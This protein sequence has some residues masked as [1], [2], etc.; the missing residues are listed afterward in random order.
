MGGF[1]LPLLGLRIEFRYGQRGAEHRF[2]AEPRPERGQVSRVEL[3]CRSDF[4]DGRSTTTSEPVAVFQRRRK[5]D[6]ER[7]LPIG[8]SVAGVKTSQCFLCLRR[9]IGTVRG[10][11]ET[12]ARGQEHRPRRDIAGRLMV[13]LDQTGR[14]RHRLTD[15]GKA[16]AANAVGR[17]L[18][19]LGR[20]HV[21]AREIAHRMVILR[22]GQSPERHWPWVAGVRRRRLIH[23]RPD[24]A[25]Q[26][27]PVGQAWLDSLLRGHVALIQPIQNFRKHLRLSEKRLSGDEAREVEFVV[28]GVLAMA[29]PAGLHHQRVN[30]LRISLRPVARHI[31]S[32]RSGER[33]A[34]H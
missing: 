32:R 2:A 10:G 7:G 11:R 29:F 3:L 4:R 15:I 26:L 21:H 8:P 25:Q 28:L 34:H 1:L 6:S 9:P 17:K 24:P 5:M 18:T 33:E 23:R 14:H 27:L 30:P 12:E 20:T 22:I 19:D 31:G 16:L 13:A